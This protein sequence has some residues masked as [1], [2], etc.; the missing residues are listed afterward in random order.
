M[1][2][3]KKILI[4][5]GYGQT[6]IQIARLLLKR[7]QHNICLAGRDQLKAARAAGELNEN[8]FGERVTGVEV[9]AAFKTQLARLFEKVDLV[10]VSMPIMGIGEKIAQAALDA[11]IDYIDLS[12]NDEKRK[13]LLKLDG[14]IRE[15]GLTFITEAGFLPGAPSV[16]A[17]YLAGYFDSVDKMT[18][19]GLFREEKESSGAGMDLVPVPGH[20]PAVFRNGSWQ[21]A[22]M[23]D[24]KRIDFG[25]RQGVKSCYPMN[26][27][28]LKGMPEE[29]GCRDLGFYASRVNRFPD[30]LNLLWETLGLSSFR[31]GADLGARLLGWGRGLFTKPT[32]ICSVKATAAGVTGGARGQLSLT[33]EHSDPNLGAAVMALPCIVGLLDGSIKKPGVHVMGHVLDPDRY[34]GNLWDMGMTV[35]LQGLSDLKQE[36]TQEQDI[37]LIEQVA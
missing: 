18:I 31:W 14:R 7:S 10:I 26:L 8:Y 25:N 36:E 9:N 13:L 5:G 3:T 16:M 15:A 6:G 37:R 32:R 23:K 27:V 35:S 28:E 17:R 19:G 11:R 33:L 24:M 20:G 34:L 21:R 2:G 1:K 12:A 30:S 29:L 22:G 4:L